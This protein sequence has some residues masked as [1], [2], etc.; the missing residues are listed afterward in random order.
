MVSF[1]PPAGSDCCEF[2]PIVVLFP[3][4]IGHGVPLSK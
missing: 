4:T 2:D 3:T 1:S